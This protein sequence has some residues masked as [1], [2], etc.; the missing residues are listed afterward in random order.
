MGLAA[1][2]WFSLGAA[3]ADPRAKL[4]VLGDSLVAGY[5]LAA[6]QAFPARLEAALAK[7]GLAL[8]AVNA[9]VS[10]DTTA[11]GL[12]RLDWLLAAQNPQFAIVE[13]GANDG[14]RG[15]DP[16][17]VFDNLDRIIA[18]MKGR[19]I[20]VLLAGMYAPP[21]LGRDYG[22]EFNAVF[23]ALAAKH[24]VAFYPFFL[25]GVAADPRLNQADR[26]HP[27][28]AGVE[29]IVERIAPHVKRLVRGF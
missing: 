3:A 19:G 21:N 29:V 25:D 20:K 22:A 12:A 6:S 7:E 26:L 27:N 13:L 24:G 8:E 14:L 2:L 11:G 5:G 28:A 23:P 17:L 10:G 16:R 1:A 15:L 4:L 18:R 9:G